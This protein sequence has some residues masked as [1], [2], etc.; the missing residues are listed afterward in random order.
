MSAAHRGEGA[1]PLW[2]AQALHHAAQEMPA[3]DVLEHEQIAAIVARHMLE[4]LPM[5][6]IQ[7]VIEQA[8]AGPGM[9]SPL[10]QAIAERACSA[11]LALLSDGEAGDPANDRETYL[12]VSRALDA[13]GAPRIAEPAAKIPGARP[14]PYSLAERVRWLGTRVHGGGER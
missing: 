3:L 4:R 1:S 8:A 6:A 9:T 11:I 14:R 5:P 13:V 2:I 12:E 7:A 10:A